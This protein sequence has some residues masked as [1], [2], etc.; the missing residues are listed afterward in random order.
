MVPNLKEI[1]KKIEELRQKIRYHNYRYYVL[2]DPLV[3]D[4]EYDQLMKELEEWEMKY[5]QYI[6][7]TSPT[8]RVGVEPV[9]GFA[10]VKHIAPLL[11]LANSFSSEEL[12]A[13]D[14][15]IKKI[16]PQ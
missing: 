16:N 9:A 11:S 10:P 3:L 15:R 8:Q 6:T 2:D 5:P 7:P 14:Q 13:F 4:I 1:E 12:R